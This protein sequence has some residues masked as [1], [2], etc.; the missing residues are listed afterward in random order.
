MSGRVLVDT[1]EGAVLDALR[2]LLITRPDLALL[3]GAAAGVP[4]AKVVVRRQVAAAAAT[5]RVA[6]V[7]GGGSGHEPHAAGMVGDGMLDA[8]VCGDV[9]AS[10]SAA[11]IVAAGE[12][13]LAALPLVS[14]DPGGG[15]CFVVKN[16]TGDRLAFALAAETLRGRGVAVEI[17]TV[18][19][20]AAV[21]GG[22]VTGRRG[23]AGTLL[24]YKVAGALA[25]AGCTLAAVCQ[26][27]AGVAGS[28]AT[29]G[30]SLSVCS[31][32]GVPRSGRLDGGVVLE[33]GLGI[34]GEPGASARTSL[35]AA[36]EL[37]AEAVTTI[38]ARLHQV[39]GT[40]PVRGAPLPVAAVVNNLGGMSGLEMGV[41]TACLARDP[42]VAI[43]RLVVGP[44]MTSLDMKGVSF[45][46]LDLRG[47]H[48]DQWL[49]S[50]DAPTAVAAWSGA[51]VPSSGVI[52][53]TGDGRFPDVVTPR[54]PASAAAASPA[55]PHPAA[56]PLVQ[57]T[58]AM[59][60]A[61]CAAMRAN[62][63]RLNDLDAVTGDGDCGSTMDAIA[64]AVAAAASDWSPVPEPPHPAAPLAGLLAECARRIAGGAGGT[65]GL[66]YALGFQAAANAAA[67]ARDGG[68][69]A[70]VRTAAACLQAAAGAIAAAARA[71]PGQRTMLDALVPL[72]A[73]L[74]AGDVAAAVAAAQA[75][76]A[77]TAHMPAGAGRA[78][79]V[80]AA[81]L[82]AA[83]VPDPGAEAV[84]IWAAA[85]AAAAAPV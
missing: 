68:S 83:A 6:V 55:G 32:P 62:A 3:D 25:R 16:Y 4:G 50:L 5:Q 85:A 15:V 35:P 64:A 54:G 66:L 10:P 65:S 13:A 49:D 81:A 73:S 31:I 78:T 72:G 24:V 75:G 80:P 74:A 29:V 63:G 79:Y 41:L 23:L 9:F 12:W 38:L 20:D 37:V 2:G 56:S 33:V 14:G 77:S 42:R 11:A 39:A 36:S 45:T 76:A 17:V 44:L 67:S 58:R 34:H 48:R 19:D 40:E 18:A 70:G 52:T 47:E 71:R 46:L 30:A 43:H 26:A 21:D 7:C 61:A 57:A 69:D 8:A 60:Q 51:A 84:A 28:V 53:A 1:A 22:P 59:L 27:A 82:A